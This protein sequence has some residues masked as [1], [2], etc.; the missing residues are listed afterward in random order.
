MA[1]TDKLTPKKEAFACKNEETRNASEA[2]RQSYDVGENT[3]PETIW[4][5]ASEL[6]ANGKVA[7][8][9]FQLQEAA[10]E[11]TL[12]TVESLTKELE[13]ARAMADGLKNPAAMTGAIMGKAKLNGLLID[14]NDHSSKDGTM[15]PPKRVTV[16]AAKPD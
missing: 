11:R 8:R 5:K 15:T 1:Q 9:V 16:Y 6:M 4:V 14:K 12:V 7:A 2:Y 10:R 13:E 3:K